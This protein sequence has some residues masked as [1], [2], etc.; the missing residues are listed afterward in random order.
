MQKVRLRCVGHSCSVLECGALP[1]H[2]RKARQGFKYMGFLYI[3]LFEN[4]VVDY[5][6]PAARGATSGKTLTVCLGGAVGPARRIFKTW[7][8]TSSEG[9]GK[10]HARHAMKTLV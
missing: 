9:P 8:S 1:N 6:R 4:M 2:I 7:S 5:I 10:K 3:A